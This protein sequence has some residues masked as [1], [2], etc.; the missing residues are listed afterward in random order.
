M[1]IDLHNMNYY[2]AIRH[3]IRRYNEL[4][5]SGSTELIEVV[6]GY[7]A[8]G[9]GGVIKRRLQA[10]LKEHRDYLDF[11]FN[12]SSKGINQ[13]CTL[14][15]PKKILPE[16]KDLLENDILDYCSNTPRT[17]EKITGHLFKKYEEKKI[18]ETVRSL[19]KKGLLSEE[20]KKRSVAYVSKHD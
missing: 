19:A 14:V 13:G 16:L 3:F 11:E 4:L 20:L 18:K 17:M 7:G 12:S 1:L 8:S 6:H 2:E 15:L 5:K 9:K 10:Y